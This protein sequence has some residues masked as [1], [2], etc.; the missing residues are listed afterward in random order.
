MGLGR[1]TATVLLVCLGLGA[2]LAVPTAA[3]AAKPTPKCR[4]NV[5]TIVGTD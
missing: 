2:Y 5:A 4:G 1:R 3:L